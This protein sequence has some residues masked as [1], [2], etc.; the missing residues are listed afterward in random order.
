M[1]MSVSDDTATGV[2]SDG[3][4]LSNDRVR[5]GVDLPE[6]ALRRGDA[7]VVRSAWMYPQRAYE[8]EF[9]SAVGAALRVLLLHEQILPGD[10]ATTSM[11]FREPTAAFL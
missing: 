9:C 2:V 6:L 3:L 10:E 8:V 5:L 7:G 4:I 11:H 1:V